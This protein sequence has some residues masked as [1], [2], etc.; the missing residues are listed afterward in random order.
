M[1]TENVIREINQYFDDGL[2]EA[3]FPDNPYRDLPF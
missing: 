1:Q 3:P 2:E